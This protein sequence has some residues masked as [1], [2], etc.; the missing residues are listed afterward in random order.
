MRKD[1]EENLDYLDE[2]D[3]GIEDE[4]QG[5]SGSPK[6]R[7]AGARA[8]VGLMVLIGSAMVGWFIYNQMHV[9]KLA[10]DPKKDKEQVMT[11]SLP[12]QSFDDVPPTIDNTPKNSVVPPLQ[13][14]QESQQQ[15]AR[16]TLNNQKKELSP[17]EKIMRARLGVSFN[18]VDPEKQATT[19]KEQERRSGQDNTE[20]SSNSQ[21]LA[22]RMKP[23]R[24]AVAQASV[25]PHPNLTIAQGTMIPC[26][27]NTELDT[28]VPGQVKCTV[29]RDVYSA[30]GTVKLIDKGA[31]VTGEQN[32]GIQNGQN[33]VFV[34]WTRLRNPDQTIVNL[35]SSGTNALGSAGIPGQYNSHW[36]ERMG[37]AVFFSVL[38]DGMKAGIASINNNNSDV[39][40][41]TTEN[42]TDQL[43]TEA[44]RAKI[45][46]P[47]TLYTAQGDAVSIYVARDLDFSTV[48]G[49]EMNE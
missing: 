8:F 14:T 27:T 18:G 16:Q 28:T 20:T 49:L 12:R 40:F 43:A 33:R 15:V 1:R 4:R 2:E 44:L 11:S 45:N 35:D 46:I 25:M 5:F 19:A 37:D 29:S 30:D 47:P 36:W 24:M 41:N 32:S 6:K 17:E 7:I 38:T 26:G 31:V 9:K 10:D 13:T 3:T 48:Y 23:A 42:S 34:L 22:S 39:S 21:A